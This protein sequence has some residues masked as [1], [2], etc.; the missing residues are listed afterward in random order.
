MAD[1]TIVQI[2]TDQT[3]VQID[4]GQSTLVQL[5]TNDST[6]IQA[7]PVNIASGTIA[8]SD[9]IPLELANVGSAGVSSVAARSDHVHPSTGHYLDGGNF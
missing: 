1:Q 5:Q 6:I 8:L 7:V 9:D 4:S 3:V 2:G